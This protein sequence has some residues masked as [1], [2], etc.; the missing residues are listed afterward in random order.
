MLGREK[1]YALYPIIIEQFLEETGL[2]QQQLQRFF[3][4]NAIEFLGLRGG[5]KTRN[6]LNAYYQLRDLDPDRLKVFDI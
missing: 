3:M 5:N 6:R 2:N 4:T 1:N